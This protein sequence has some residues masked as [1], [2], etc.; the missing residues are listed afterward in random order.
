[1]EQ[2]I[3]LSKDGEDGHKYLLQC[4]R[5][6]TPLQIKVDGRDDGGE[7]LNLILLYLRVP[8]LKPGSVIPHETW[9]TTV[10]SPLDAHGT[11]KVATQF[12][13]EENQGET[14]LLKFRQT[15]GQIVLDNTHTMR[16]TTDFW[17]NAQTG[18]VVMMKKTVGQYIGKQAAEM[19][20]MEERP[21]PAI[22]NS[23]R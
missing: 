8:I 19:I 11:I 9:Q 6:G 10:A 7:G 18:T 22:R 3:F 4:G 2:Q 20:T 14:R 5:R 12:L 23:S 15:V 13:G 1:M 17:V 16:D 21:E